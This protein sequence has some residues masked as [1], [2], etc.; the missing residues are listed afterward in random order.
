MQIFKQITANHLTL[1]EFKFRKELAMEAYLIENET[2][3]KLDNLEFNEVE[4][5]DAEIALKAGRKSQEKNGRIDLLVKYGS[6]YLGIVELKLEQLYEE[7]L[8]QLEDYLQERNQLL[9]KYPEFWGKEDG[10]TEPKWIGVLVGNSADKGLIEKINNG[11]KFENNIPIAI[12]LLNRFKNTSNNEIYVISDTYFKNN[13]VARDYSKFKLNNVIYNKGK[14]VNAVIKE[15][16]SQNPDITFSEL[17]RNFPKSIQGS[18]GVFSTKLEAE[19]IY[20]RTNRTRHHIKPEEFINLSD[21]IIATSS[22]WNSNN[23]KV[24]IDQVKKLTTKI[25]IE[26]I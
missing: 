26:M 8:L 17:E 11:Y 24:F 5:I 1:E 2:I 12:I 19:E 22:Q 25:N 14:L 18:L 20:I 15:Y 21:S 4:I 6:E 13:N 3:L 10:G 7:H 9:T 16:V 23:I